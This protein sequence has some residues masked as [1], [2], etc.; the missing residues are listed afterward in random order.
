MKKVVWSLV[1]LV[2]AISCGEE[3]KAVD[4]NLSDL[5]TAVVSQSAETCKTG[6]QVEFSTSGG[7]TPYEYSVN[8]ISFQKEAVFKNLSAGDY[9]LLTRDD[10]N[11]LVETAFAIASEI[12][13]F[14]VVVEEIQAAG[15]DGNTGEATVNV[16]GGSGPYT[17]ILDGSPMNDQITYTNLEKGTHT[18]SITDIEGCDNDDTFYIPS[19]ISFKDEIQPII[20]NNCA[21]EGCHVAGNAIVPFT[22]FENIQSYAQLIKT[23][24]QNKTMPKDGSITDEEIQML[25]C[26]VDD[27]A[28]NN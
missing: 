28:L 23:N 18:L 14:T 2:L 24:T 1:V 16:T 4:C 11:C 27:G 8:G 5:S 25:A 3:D 22:E 7:D 13:E 19:G 21:I 15:C 17:Y 6:G 20:T 10:N 12:P 26:W 9:V